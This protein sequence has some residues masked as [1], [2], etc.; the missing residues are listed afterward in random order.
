[1][2]SKWFIVAI[3]L[4]VFVLLCGAGIAAFSINRLSANGVQWRVGQ[5]DRVS[6]EGSQDWSFKAGGPAELVVDSSFG[7]ITITGA[8]GDEVKVTAH[9][10]AWDSTQERAEAALAEMPIEVRQD[11]D[12]IVVRY[13]P[14]TQML[15]VGD[16]RAD[17]VDFTISVPQDAS[18]EVTLSSGDILLTGVTG[19]ADLEN[20]FGNI[21]VEDLEGGLTLK[22]NSGDARAVRIQAGQSPVKMESQFG[23]LRLEQASASQVTL[24]GNSG[25][26]DLKAVQASGDITIDNQFGDIRFEEGGAAALNVKSN[27]GKL[28]LSGIKLEGALTAD[29]QFGDIDIEKVLAASYDLSA[30]S[31]DI[32]MQQAQGKVKAFT[33]FG[34]I[35][36]REAQQVQ[37]DLEANSGG[38]EFSG[39]LGD[40]PHVLKTQFGDVRM[41][42]PKDAA[43]DFDLKTEFGRLKS[44]FPVTISGE[45]DEKHWVG[46]INGG[47]AS[48]TVEVN[49]GNITLEVISQ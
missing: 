47:G 21:T 3:V 18:A 32:S 34:G 44:A 1:M 26:I 38:I 14:P 2:R 28:T 6:A 17:S 30:N 7:D 9:K 43:L 25:Q 39:S 22:T 49:S 36:I 5:V 10:T 4:L 16:M 41:A 42:L 8:Q 12:K 33:Q 35:T 40:G 20:Q 45:I 24:S 13:K 46:V 11:G 37:L 19:S 27:S 29:S 48:L 15:V 23:D 31:G